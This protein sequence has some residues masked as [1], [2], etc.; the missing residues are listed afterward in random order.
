LFIIGIPA[1]YTA[2][3]IGAFGLLEIILLII[4]AVIGLVFQLLDIEI[5]SAVKK[6]LVLDKC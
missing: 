5:S 4:A 2:Q 6:P 1:V 3:P